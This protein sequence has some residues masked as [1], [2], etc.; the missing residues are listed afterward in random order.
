M[1]KGDRH[2]DHRRQVVGWLEGD[3]KGWWLCVDEE[4]L[5]VN[6]RWARCDDLAERW[7]LWNLSAGGKRWDAIPALEQPRD[8]LE[9]QPGHRFPRYLKSA[10][11][12]SAKTTRGQKKKTGK[13]RDLLDVAWRGGL[14]S[15]GKR[16]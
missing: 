12:N 16:R 6:P 13:G 5:P 11:K 3:E 1:A 14:P 8:L 10:R 4:W 7:L 2:R 15:L 9:L